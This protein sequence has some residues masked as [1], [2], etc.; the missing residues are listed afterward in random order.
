M[1]FALVTGLRGFDIPQVRQNVTAYRQARQEAGH[2]GPG[3]VYIRIPVYVADTAEQARTEPEASTM[4][5][6]R[7]LAETFA[8]SA[9]QMGTT[10]AEERTERAARLSQVTYD[11][12]LRDRVAYGTPDMVVE[13]LRQLRDELGLSGVIMESNVGGFIPLDRVL[14]SIRLFAQEVASRLRASGHAA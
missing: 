1:G 13:R 2:S 3:G 5:A 11:D 8:R 4:R 6:Y 14:H 10:G 9:G 12:L 7:R